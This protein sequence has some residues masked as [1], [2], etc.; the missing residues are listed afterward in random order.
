MLQ[1]ADI[2]VQ[3]KYSYADY[4]QWRFEEMVELI[5][6]KIVKMSPAPL[7]LHQKTVTNLSGELYN[8]LKRKPCKMRIAPFDVRLLDGKK[9]AVAD[10]EIFTV[11]QPDIC[12]ICDEKKLDVRGCIGA[13][14]MITEILSRST[15]A[16]DLTV[17]YDLYEENGVKEYWIISPHD[18]IIQVFDLDAT[19]Q[20]Y[21]RRGIYTPENCTTVRV[22]SIQHDILIEDIFY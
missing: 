9:T 5:K 4:L 20:K 19:T 8:Y 18:Q 14:D 7:D 16:K 10:Q 22:Q 12:I 21:Q 13:P 1:L 3:Q 6:G 17:K 11:V 15:A 2:D